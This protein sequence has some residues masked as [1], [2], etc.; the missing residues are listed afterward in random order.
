MDH[1]P[2]LVLVG[3]LLEPD[4]F[5]GWKKVLVRRGGITMLLPTCVFSALL[6]GQLLLCLSLSPN[7]SL[8]LLQP[9]LLSVCLVPPALLH[10]PLVGS[11]SGVRG[12]DPLLHL[13]QLAGKPGEIVVFLRVGRRRSFLP[14]H[15]TVANLKTWLTLNIK[16]EGPLSD[17][18]GLR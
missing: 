18:C 3:N 15:L 6:T 10:Q 4:G 11:Q 1:L 7:L 16:D 12:T 17:K 8:F 5:S 9:D 13:V 2:R 14:Q